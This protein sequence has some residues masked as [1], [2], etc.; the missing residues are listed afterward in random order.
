[1]RGQLDELKERLNEEQRLRMEAQKA[2][3]E[4]RYA[5]GEGEFSASVGYQP[6]E[7]SILGVEEAERM[8]APLLR[9]VYAENQRLKSELDGRLKAA[10][11]NVARLAESGLK[12]QQTQR[13]AQF[14]QDVVQ[15]APN[16]SKHVA[17]PA[18]RAYL[19]RPVT[20]NQSLQI[21]DLLLDALKKI[22]VMAVADIVGQYEAGA[23]P[24]DPALIAQVSA[25]PGL[26]PAPLP[27]TP[28]TGPDGRYT[29]DYR[30]ALYDRM[31][32]EG[33]SRAEIRRA[34]RPNPR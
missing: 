28:P 12:A 16:I 26:G 31:K 34:L 18:F 15:A 14:N 7:V 10:E 23:S 6:E 9:K 25:A 4:A 8:A 24:G 29:E 17:D 11:E 27:E 5:R 13:Q 2:L 33:R 19:D 20:P 3:D 22:N 32:S 30:A 1:M 21:H